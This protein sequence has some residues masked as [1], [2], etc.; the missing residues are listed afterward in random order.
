[1]IFSGEWGLSRCDPMASLDG[2]YRSFY[3]TLG[4]IKPQRKES[5]QNGSDANDETGAEK[6]AWVY[7]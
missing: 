3:A 1:M 4:M 2:K 7:L 6:G 5:K